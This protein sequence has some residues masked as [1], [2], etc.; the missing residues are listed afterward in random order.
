MNNHFVTTAKDW[1]DLQEIHAPTLKNEREVGNKMNIIKVGLVLANIEDCKELGLLQDIDYEGKIH[2][3]TVVARTKKKEILFR[4]PLE[5]S[6]WAEQSVAMAQMGLNA[7]PSV[8]E[9]GVLNGGFFA[10]IH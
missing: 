3:P 5:L 2:L 1:F 10:E 7:F 4:L 8:V 9:F 6:G